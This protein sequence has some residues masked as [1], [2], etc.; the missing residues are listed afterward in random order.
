MFILYMSFL[1][2]NYY[3]TIGISSFKGLDIIILYYSLN[4]SLIE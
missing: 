2:I 3:V 4:K 1:L